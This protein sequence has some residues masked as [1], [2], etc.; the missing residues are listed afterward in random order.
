[1][2]LMPKSLL[3][4]QSFQARVYDPSQAPK[5]PVTTPIEKGRITNLSKMIANRTRVDD[6][7]TLSEF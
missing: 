6:T 7:D 3:K 2:N 4:I 5:R 1:M